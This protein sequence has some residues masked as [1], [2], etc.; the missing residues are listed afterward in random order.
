MLN[1]F[2]SGSPIPIHC[3]RK[4]PETVLCFSGRFDRGFYDESV[5]ISRTTN[6]Q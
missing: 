6:T 5:L 2:E 4:S 3:H 1:A